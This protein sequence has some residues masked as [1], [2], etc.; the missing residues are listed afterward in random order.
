MRESGEE[1]LRL[2]LVEVG[3]LMNASG[4]NQGTS[5]NLSVRLDDAR[6]LITPTGQSCESLRSSELAVLH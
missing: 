6:L 2:E 4:L 3:R 5:G 1:A